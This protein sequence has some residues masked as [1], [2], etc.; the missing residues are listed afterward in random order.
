MVCVVGTL[1]PFGDSYAR[2]VHCYRNLF[3]LCYC[4]SELIDQDNMILP[5]ALTIT[6]SFDNPVTDVPSRY[7]KH[8][9]H[10]ET[11]LLQDSYQYTTKDINLDPYSY[12]KQQ[13]SDIL[14]KEISKE[15]LQDEE[16]KK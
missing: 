10:T 16:D 6:L 8:W 4:D 11:I 5:L 12:I 7:E 3:W 1:K 15:L 14:Y 13:N 9:Q 2:N